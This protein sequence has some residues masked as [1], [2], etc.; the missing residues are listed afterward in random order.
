MKRG[1]L[2]SIILT[3]LLCLTPF[4]FAQKEWVTVSQ[5]Q[6]QAGFS[7]VFFVDAQNGW[8]VGSDSTI[9]NTTDGGKTWNHQPNRPL[10]FKIELKKV[11]FINPKIGWVVGENGTVLKTLDG[12]KQWSKLTT[13]TRVALLGVSFADEQHG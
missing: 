3:L 9:L 7:D 11:R 1:I 5:S 12:G 13:N 6:W 2:F 10:P 4:V 8:I